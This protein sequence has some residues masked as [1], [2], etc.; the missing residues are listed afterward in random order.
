MSRIKAFIG[1]VCCGKSTQIELA[2]KQM[3]DNRVVCFQPG[4]VLRDTIGTGIMS[5]AENPNAPGGEIDNFVKEMCKSALYMAWD[6]KVPA[7]LDGY[8]RTV[9]QSKRLHA[10]L[11]SGQRFREIE[12]E[13]VYLNPP[14]EV[15]HERIKQRGSRDFDRLRLERSRLD[16]A[17]VFEWWTDL[18][19]IGVKYQIRLREDRT[20]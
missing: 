15:V 14:I 7:I 16:A 9:H 5:D 8:P 4:K 18:K 10:I 2:R 6:L 12:F 20:S 11:S 13:L 17:Q 3:T 1:G 19:A